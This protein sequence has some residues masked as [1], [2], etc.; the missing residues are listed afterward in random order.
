M[1]NEMV[2]IYGKKLDVEPIQREAASG[3]IFENDKILVVY[4]SNN[5]CFLP[6]YVSH[7]RSRGSVDKAD[8]V[9]E[10]RNIYALSHYTLKR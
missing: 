3:V 7:G 9:R 5:M 1:Q 8:F 10:Y 6:L 4:D 2:P